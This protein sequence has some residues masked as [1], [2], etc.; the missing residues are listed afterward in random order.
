MDIYIIRKCKVEMKE[1]PG[2]NGAK[3]RLPVMTK[4]NIHSYI[5]KQTLNSLQRDRIQ[6]DLEDFYTKGEKNERAI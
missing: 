5:V 2:V 4:E 3:Y 1:F 6:R